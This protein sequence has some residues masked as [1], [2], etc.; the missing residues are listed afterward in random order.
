MTK[1]ERVTVKIAL[2]LLSIKDEQ[3]KRQVIH[4]ALDMDNRARRGW[5]TV[6]GR[7]A[8]NKLMDKLRAHLIRE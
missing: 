8:F 4:E 1:E 7:P 2:L 6:P 3:T 5:W